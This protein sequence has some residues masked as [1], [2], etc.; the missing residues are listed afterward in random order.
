MALLSHQSLPETNLNPDTNIP[1]H[2]NLS[3][4][5]LPT[6]PMD[7]PATKFSQNISQNIS[8]NLSQ[9]KIAANINIAAPESHAQKVVMRW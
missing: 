1:S 9:N 6:T 2:G 5:N 4:W 8:Q 7:K 3:Q